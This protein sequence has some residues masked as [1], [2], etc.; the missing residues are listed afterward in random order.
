MEVGV[1]KAGSSPADANSVAI[2][3]VTGD[4]EALVTLAAAKEIV[5]QRVAAQAETKAAETAAKVTRKAAANAA[6]TAAKA[7]A[8]AAKAAAKGKAA[9]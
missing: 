6:S 4:T 8:R 7:E 3:S 2:G 5:K 1:L 9:G